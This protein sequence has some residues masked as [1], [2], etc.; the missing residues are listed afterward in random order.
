MGDGRVV[1]SSLRITM[2]TKLKRPPNLQAYTF[3]ANDLNKPLSCLDVAA[4]RKS[5]ILITNFLFGRMVLT[6]RHGSLA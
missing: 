6:I 5:S 1:S 3:I 4:K 2:P